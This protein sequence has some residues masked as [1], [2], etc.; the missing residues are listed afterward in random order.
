M[1]RFIDWLLDRYFIKRPRFRRFV[2]RLIER[3]TDRQIDLCGTTL[4]INS[5]KEHGYLRAARMGQSSSVF[6]QEV[7][8]LINLAFLLEPGDTFIDIGANVGLYSR[9]MARFAHLVPGFR[10]YSFEPHPDTYQRLA[11]ALPAGVQAEQVA[12]SDRSG[13]LEF[14]E[15]VVSHVFTASTKANNYHVPG[16]TR[17]IPTQRLD[18]CGIQGDSLVIKIDV[19]GQEKEVLLGMTG[20]LQAGRVKALYLDGHEDLSIEDMLRSFGFRLFDGR[21]LEPTTRNVFTLLAVQP[22]KYPSLCAGES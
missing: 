13:T 20:L 9:T 17:P 11:Q 4:H 2:T 19:E 15:G 7:A 16:Q 6:Q 18:E 3:D 5:I 8:V 12:L 21:T 10:V 14:V 22:A 1:R